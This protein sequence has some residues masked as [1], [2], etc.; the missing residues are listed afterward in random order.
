MLAT[1]LADPPPGSGSVKAV[2]SHHQDPAGTGPG[3]RG[4][5]QGMAACR[6]GSRRAQP[7]A[8]PPPPRRSCTI[9]ATSPPP[10]APPASHPHR[11]QRLTIDE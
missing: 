2:S 7:R 9:A 5:G 3:V 8:R 11:R 4:S 6:V 10:A 1:A